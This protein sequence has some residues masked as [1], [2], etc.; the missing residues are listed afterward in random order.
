MHHRHGRRRTDLPALFALKKKKERKERR[1]TRGGGSASSELFVCRQDMM[2]DDVTRSPE[3]QEEQTKM[4]IPAAGMRSTLAR[5]PRGGYRPSVI[6]R[7]LDTQHKK[8]KRETYPSIW[9]WRVS[10]FFSNRGWRGSKGVSRD[11]HDKWH[12]RTIGG[13][14]GMRVPKSGE[15]QGGWKWGILTEA[16]CQAAKWSNHQAK[17]KKKSH[18][19]MC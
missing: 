5:R 11:V 6:D 19:S 13:S 12:V 16:K 9:Q 4:N 15:A 10:F 2:R 1:G 8:R 3:K 14:V 18:R 17:K 7:R